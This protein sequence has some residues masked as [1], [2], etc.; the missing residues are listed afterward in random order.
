MARAIKAVLLILVA[1]FSLGPVLWQA[2]TSIKPDHLLVRLPPILPET[3][4]ADHYRAVFGTGSIHHEL[5]NSAVVA[6]CTT[7]LAVLIGGLC[8]FAVARLPL[9]GKSA[10]LGLALAIS[11]FPSIAVISP[12]YLLARA[13]GLRDTLTILVLVHTTYALP[14]AIWVLTSFFR[15][16]PIELYWAARVDG[17]SPW[18]A[19]ISVV[20]PPA[21]PGVAV[22]ALLIFIFSW[23]EFMFAL[24]LTASEHARTAPVAIALF[25]GLHDVPWGDMAAASIVV[26][27]PVLLLAVVFQRHIVAGLSAGSV[28]G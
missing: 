17:C 4:T 2:I 15:Q 18:R 25:P 19:L 16:V 6:G 27:I 12:L 20:L 3:A 24:T 14:L 22:A 26:T 28:K 9:A 11:M 10:I 8:A 1:T 7:M 21:M 23:N 5:F 13:T